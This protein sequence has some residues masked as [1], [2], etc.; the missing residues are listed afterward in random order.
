MKRCTLYLKEHNLLRQELQGLK[1]CQLRFLTL[2]VTVTALLLGYIAHSN[3]GSSGNTYYLFPLVIVIPSWWIFFDKAKSIS[4]IVG[5]YRNLE[6]LILQDD[7]DL[8]FDG[9][10]NA[11]ERF[12]KQQHKKSSRHDIGWGKKLSRLLTT[13]RYLSCLLYTSP[14]PRDRTRSRM[15]SSA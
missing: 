10:E 5:Y 2:S 14:S 15:P 7:S 8:Q 11:L 3:P 1:E 12:R 6:D 9:W 4:R 13:H